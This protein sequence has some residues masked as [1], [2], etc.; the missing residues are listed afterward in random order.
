MESVISQTSVCL[1]F[2]LE[3]H[4]Q[5]VA[6]DSPMRR[7][8]WERFESRIER[9]ADKIL[10]LLAECKARATFFVHGWVAERHGAVVQ[11]IADEGHE[12]A[13]HGYANEMVTAQAP[14]QFREDVRRTRIILE[15][16]TGKPVLGYRAPNLAFTDDVLWALPIL[17]EEGYQYTSSIVPARAWG[18]GGASVTRG[19]QQIFTASGP[20]WALPPRIIRIGWTALP[21]SGGVYFRLTP[22]SMFRRSILSERVIQP[23]VLYFRAWE[24]DPKQPRMNGRALARFGHYCNL[25]KVETRLRLLLREFACGPLYEAIERQDVRLVQQLAVPAAR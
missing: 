7:R 25:K 10:T 12:V 17:V 14:R 1:S 2:D 18:N 20:L 19:P 16:L 3:E 9:N 21:Y 11:R 6:F 15:D 23:V 4:F 13:S 22:Y 5:V 8:H 24:L